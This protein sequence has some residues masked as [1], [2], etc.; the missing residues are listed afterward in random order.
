[1]RRLWNPNRK[2]LGE[3]PNIHRFLWSRLAETLIAW[4]A[5]N[6]PR[7]QGAVGRDLSDRLLREARPTPPGG[8]R[9]CG[10]ERRIG[11]AGAGDRTALRSPN[12][13]A[14]APAECP[15]RLPVFAAWC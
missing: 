12:P 6:E 9:S 5:D 10:G 3:T 11:R 4:I 13:A 2:S 15:P 8:G 1:M 7:P 14:S